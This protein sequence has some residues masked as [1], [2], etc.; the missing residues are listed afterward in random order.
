MIDASGDE[1]GVDACIGKELHF[2]YGYWLIGVSKTLSDYREIRNLMIDWRV[3][4][5]MKS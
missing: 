1:F 4:V 5:K 2:R 3:F